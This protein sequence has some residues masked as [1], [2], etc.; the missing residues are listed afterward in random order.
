MMWQA[1]TAVAGRPDRTVYLY[2]FV[3]LFHLWQLVLRFEIVQK[4]GET[5][6]NITSQTCTNQW[7]PFVRYAQT[8]TNQW[9][10]FV[11]HAQTCWIC[12]YPVLCMLARVALKGL[13]PV[14]CLSS[15]VWI[16]VLQN[17]GCGWCRRGEK[18]GM[19]VEMM[20]CSLK[21]RSQPCISIF[22]TFMAQD[23][24]SSNPGSH[25]LLSL[26]PKNLF[27]KIIFMPKIGAREGENN[28][29]LFQSKKAVEMQDTTPPPSLMDK[30][31][32]FRI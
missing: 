27:F 11:R 29:W 6:R 7:R 31:W 15:L 32:H 13:I 23:Q 20:V 22:Y 26:G 25:L 16:Q 5:V 14:K 28:R 30:H 21:N 8:F 12:P 24:R 3:C 19:C 1:S 4:T 17:V 10:P 2:V 18:G 9:R